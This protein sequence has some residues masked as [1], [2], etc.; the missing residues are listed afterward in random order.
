M[1]DGPAM[2]PAATD[3]PP[4]GF[5]SS[6]PVPPVIEAPPNPE[7]LRAL[8]RLV[9]GLSILFWGLPVALVACVQTGR[10]DWF[11]PLG[12]FPPVGALLLLLYGLNQLGGF[13]PQERPWRAALDRFRLLAVI[14]LGLVPFLYW[15]NRI[16]SNAFF[17]T[18]IEVLMLTGLLSLYLLNALLCRLTAMLP[19]E[20]LR[21]ETRLFTGINRWLLLGLMLFLA[22]YFIGLHFDPVLPEKFLGWLLRISPLPNQTSIFVQLVDHAG[23]WFILFFILLPVAMTMALLWKTKSVILASIF[24]ADH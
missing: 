3:A 5:L 8:G 1:Q 11:R 15:W 13:Q 21:M 2:P 4:P 14:D 19:D 17:S 22:A 16:P 6:R 10:G 23:Q 24:G 20:T 7:L 12:V 18:M 9:R